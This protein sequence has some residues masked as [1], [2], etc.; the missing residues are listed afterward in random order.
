ME[1]KIITIWS[2]RGNVGVSS[3]AISMAK[4][5]ED[6]NKKVLLVDFNLVQPRLHSLLEFEA[7]NHTIDCLFPYMI[8]NSE[9][10]LNQD[11]IEMNCEKLND[12]LFVL[13]GTNSPSDLYGQK[14]VNIAIL[15]RLLESFKNNYDYILLDVHH[16]LTNTAT[17]VALEKSDIVLTVLNKQYL[18]NVSFKSI[19]EWL[20]ENF[21]K[22]KFKF[23]INGDKK[24]SVL[25]NKDIETF[26]DE[27][28]EFS[29]PFVKD[30]DEIINLNSLKN[31][32]KNKKLKK[33]YK[34]IEKI[35]KEIREE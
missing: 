12:N 9:E 4:E 20:F 6:K 24:T 35:I 11:I 34:S 16:S 17:Y 5:I 1:G 2:S 10:S 3:L 25:T 29:I 13:K 32:D 27:K 22:D 28:I 7:D 8:D 19:K 21:K 18:T 14:F 33:Y 26:I 30:F 31:S 15:E 23:V